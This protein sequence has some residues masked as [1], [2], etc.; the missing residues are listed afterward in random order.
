MKLE[1]LI[2]VRIEVKFERMMFGKKVLGGESEL[3]AYD[4]KDGSVIWLID[5]LQWPQRAN[6]FYRL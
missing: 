4:I 6:E 2:R 3:W 1:H 5:H